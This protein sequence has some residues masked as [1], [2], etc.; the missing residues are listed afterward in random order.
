MNNTQ[1]NPDLIDCHRFPTQT[2]CTNS[3]VVGT[4]LRVLLCLV[5][6]E[7]RYVVKEEWRGFSVRIGERGCERRRYGERWWRWVLNR[8][9]EM[10]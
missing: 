8:R 2:D 3:Q 9:G 10:E 6:T 4:L 1:N 5:W 7:K